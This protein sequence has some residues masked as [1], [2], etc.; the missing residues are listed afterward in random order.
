MSAP[1]YDP[2]DNSRRCYELAIAAAREACIRRGTIKPDPSRPQEV[3]WAQEGSVSPDK[4][5]CV[6]G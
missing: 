1:D 3:R 6:R 2:D 5:E 4:L